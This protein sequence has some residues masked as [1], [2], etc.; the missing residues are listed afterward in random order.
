[1]WRSGAG[2]ISDPVLID[3]RH[4]VV[5]CDALAGRGPMRARLLREDIVWRAD[6]RALR[7]I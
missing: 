1:M 6:A 5:A 3:D 4:P 7:T 2:V